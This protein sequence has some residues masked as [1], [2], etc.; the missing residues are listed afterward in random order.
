MDKQIPYA[1]CD[2]CSS[3]IAAT[4]LLHRISDYVQPGGPEVGR[5]DDI[6]D[7][8]FRWTS[9]RLQCVEESLVC[10]R[11]KP[12]CIK[13]DIP[14]DGNMQD[15]DPA[16]LLLECLDS[17]EVRQ[18]TSQQGSISEIAMT[19]AIVAVLY[20]SVR[21]TVVPAPSKP[22]CDISI[23]SSARTNLP[24][25]MGGHLPEAKQQVTS[26]AYCA[27]ALLHSVTAVCTTSEMVCVK[28]SDANK[29]ESTT[30]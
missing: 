27:F 5:N 8:D 1:C 28:V 19:L 6:A 16:A 14:A 22:T 18:L 15:T 21:H 25:K 26:R 29:D 3:I 4:A 10:T 11:T 30:H 12:V 20:Q 24:A 2:S 13:F 23:N 9:L 17:V 7:G